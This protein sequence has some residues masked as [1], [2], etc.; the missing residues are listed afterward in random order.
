MKNNKKILKHIPRKVLPQ[1]ASEF[2]MNRSTLY[3]KLQREEWTDP[4]VLRLIELAK[5]VKQDKIEIEK[6][7]KSL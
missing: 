6:Q 2:G 1:V 5:E 4:A 7:I 3:R